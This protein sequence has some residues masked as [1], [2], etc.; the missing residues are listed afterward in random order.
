MICTSSENNFIAARNWVAIL[1][2]TLI[3]VYTQAQCIVAAQTADDDRQQKIVERFLSLLKRNPREGTAFDRVYQFH[4]DQ[5]SLQDFKKR[6]EGAAE[7]PSA[8]GSEWMILGLCHL[9]EHKPQ[10]AAEVFA[11]ADTL[12]SDD[13]LAAWYLARALTAAGSES[14]GSQGV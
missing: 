2:T 14:T 13:P 4:I 10:L 1:L 9:R 12:R 6:L 8:D 3:V 5:S 7:S 11:K